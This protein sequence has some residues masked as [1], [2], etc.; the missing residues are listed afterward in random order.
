MACPQDG[1]Y[2]KLVHRQI[3]KASNEILNDGA[4]DEEAGGGEGGRGGRGG[5]GG[6]R[7][8]RGGGRGGRG[9]RRMQGGGGD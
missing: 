6:G 7:G 9:R 2:S 5:R 8:G 1:A 4:F 3:T